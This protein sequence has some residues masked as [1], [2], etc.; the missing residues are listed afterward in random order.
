MFFPMYFKIDCMDR[1]LTIFF[2]FC[3]LFLAGLAGWWFAAEDPAP[4][5]N[6]SVQ[7]AEGSPDEPNGRDTNIRESGRTEPEFSSDSEPA[8]TAKVENA[9]KPDYWRITGQVKKAFTQ[10]YQPLDELKLSEVEIELQ[11]ILNNEP[12]AEQYTFFVETDDT[13]R[14]M[15]E[16]YKDYLPTITGYWRISYEFDIGNQDVGEICDFDDWYVEEDETI[17]LPSVHNLLSPTVSSDE[18]ILG[19]LEL[20][21]Q[22]AAYFEADDEQIVY[23]NIAHVSGVPMANLCDITL[24][25]LDEYF[26]DTG[27][28]IICYPDDEKRNI[29]GFQWQLLAS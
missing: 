4:G 21:F 29:H 24:V 5:L 11:T 20:N 13:G 7:A 23:G 8:P 25:I 18:L 26:E 17:D 12:N 6:G 10:K 3:I 15:L 28:V 2:L 1:K 27:E 16:I 14:F 9:P 19:T 22:T